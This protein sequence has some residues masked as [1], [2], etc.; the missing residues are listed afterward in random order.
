[1][2]FSFLETILSDESAVSTVR[3]Y[4]LPLTKSGFDVSISAVDHYYAFFG[5]SLASSDVPFT[6]EQKER[7]EKQ[8]SVLY[9]ELDE[10]FIA[11]IKEM[12]SGARARDSIYN[13]ILVIIREE[14]S[15]VNKSVDE[16][17]EIINDRVGTLWS[18]RN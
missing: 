4:G 2:I 17:C 12:L 16:V 8:G 6:E 1:M 14:L 7:Y 3:N 9:V 5:R 18:E 11:E 10:K 15:A 13:D